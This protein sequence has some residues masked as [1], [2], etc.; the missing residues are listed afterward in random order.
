MSIFVI[1]GILTNAIKA[2][3]LLQIK[4]I[5]DMTWM[6]KCLESWMK[7]QHNSQSELGILIWIDR[8]LFLNSSWVGVLIPRHYLSI[9]TFLSNP[10]C[11][12]E[13]RRR[14]SLRY[15][16][17]RQLISSLAQLAIVYHHPW[18]LLDPSAP[19]A[20]LSANSPKLPPSRTIWKLKNL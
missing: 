7:S 9:A 6:S 10:V 19:A 4:L 14:S 13:T 11:Q 17:M 20:N 15:A 12:T 2:R 16:I 18:S 5:Q 1:W 3:D 8:R